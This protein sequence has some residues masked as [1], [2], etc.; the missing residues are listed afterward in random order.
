MAEKDIDHAEL[1]ELVHEPA[2]R[3]DDPQD[4]ACS[5]S[6]CPRRRRLR[7]DLRFKFRRIDGAAAL[8]TE[9]PDHIR[10]NRIRYTLTG[11][12]GSDDEVDSGTGDK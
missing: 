6:D 5:I 2:L 7:C 4:I 3:T 1:W 8:V 10:R 11:H 9:F 12:F